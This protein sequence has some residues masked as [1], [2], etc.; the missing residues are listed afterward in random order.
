MTPRSGRGGLLPLCTSVRARG[1][2]RAWSS[3]TREVSTVPPNGSVDVLREPVPRRMNVRF[4]GPRPP[5]EG[6]QGAHRSACRGP[7]PRGGSS[8][9]G[10]HGPSLW[11][12]PG[13]PPLP[14]SCL[15]R[16]LRD[17]QPHLWGPRAAVGR[18]GA[19][20]GSGGPAVWVGASS[21]VACSA[22][23]SPLHT[24]AAASVLLQEK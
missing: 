21:H 18:L 1:G 11:A 13:R 19:R 24:C 12:A 6:A 9:P 8:P 20:G 5:G 2:P 23:L 17:P 3:L 22:T 7:R 4:R 15:G 16:V 10:V 14:E